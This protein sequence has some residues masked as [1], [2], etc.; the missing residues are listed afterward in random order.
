MGTSS[1][2]RLGDSVVQANSFY[3]SNDFQVFAVP[4]GWIMDASELYAKSENGDAVLEVSGMFPGP[5]EL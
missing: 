1:W 5:G 4:D 3:Y 2:V